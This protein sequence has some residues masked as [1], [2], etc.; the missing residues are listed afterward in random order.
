MLRLDVSRDGTWRDAA[1]H[2]LHPAEAVAQ[3]V[4]CDV[5]F[6]LVHGPGGEDGT[7]AALAASG[8]HEAE[9]SRQLDLLLDTLL[10]RD[11]MAFVAGDGFLRLSSDL[12]T[13]AAGVDLGLHAVRRG[14]PFDW[15]PL[16][17]A[18]VDAL[19][20]LPVPDA[21]AHLDVPDALADEVIGHG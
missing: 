2:P 17:R 10:H 8:E 1:G 20:A 16:G 15:L 21:A 7:L 3:L 19:N 9:A 13:G 11:G 6:P 14:R 18:S 4:A 5:L 12:A